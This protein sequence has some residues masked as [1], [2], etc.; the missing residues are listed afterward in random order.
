MRLWTRN[1]FVVQRTV[2]VDADLVTAR[3]RAD[4]ASV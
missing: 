4:I 3:F 2:V 1:E